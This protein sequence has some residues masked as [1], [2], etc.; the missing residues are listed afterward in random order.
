M[1]YSLQKIRDYVEG[2]KIPTSEGYIEVLP[3]VEYPVKWI[4]KDGQE[5]SD[6]FQIK[7]YFHDR[8]LRA[9]STDFE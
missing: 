5:D 2:D 6:G 3:D 1:N 7:F 9:Y 4:Y 8:W